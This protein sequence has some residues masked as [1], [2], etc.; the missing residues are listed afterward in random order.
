MKTSDF[1]R[2]ARVQVPVICG[3]MYPCSNPELVA[4]V[5]R[6]GGL[7]V[8]QPLSLVFVYKYDLRAGLKKINELSG[9]RPYGFNVLIEASSARYI[10]RM[11]TWV[12]IA[13]EE[14]CRF[15]ISALGNPRWFA[16]RIHRAGGIL[17]HD[18]TELKWA[19][20]AL[21][22][23]ADG[24][25]C[26]N[27]RA[28]GHLG[29]QDPRRLFEELAPL[30]KP[31]ICAGGVASADRFAEMLAL[32]YAGVQMGTRFIATEECQAHGDYK[33]AILRAEESDIVS[34]EILT[35]VPVS[36]IAT[37]SVLKRGLA[38]GPVLKFLLRH[39]KLKH[40]ARL[41]YQ[42]RS[43]WT[44]KKASLE[45]L[46]Y[47]DYWQAGKSVSG[48]ERVESAATIVRG[49]DEAYKRSINKANLT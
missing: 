46:S 31:L 7:G 2:D 48:I 11:K 34:T 14:G 9:G 15:F 41:Y 35:G 4:A 25:I 28:G 23:G 27:N 39:R 12:E 8:V 33:A 40:W 32:G 5:S 19:R 22:G 1:C 47:K 30:G 43:L 45:G 49:F 42:V 16:D 38:A 44:L 29:T 24:L 18:V 26:V 13:L 6:A 10:E 37:P 36:I 17:Y 21:D 3:A 20:K